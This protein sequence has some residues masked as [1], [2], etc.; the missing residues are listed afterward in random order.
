MAIATVHIVAADLELA[1]SYDEL[2]DVL[3]LVRPDR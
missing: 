2:G 1:G 3:Y